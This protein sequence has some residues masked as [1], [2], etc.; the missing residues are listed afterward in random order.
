MR[1]GPETGGS[2]TIPLTDGPLFILED[3]FL[4][5]KEGTGAMREEQFQGLFCIWF[6]EET[7]W[8]ERG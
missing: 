1:L 5:R 7:R 6:E 2:A 3:L 8:R 4:Q